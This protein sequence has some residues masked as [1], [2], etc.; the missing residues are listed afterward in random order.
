MCTLIRF[1]TAPTH[2]RW[3]E[4]GRIAGAAG[5]LALVISLCFG[6]ILHPALVAL[7]TLLDQ[8]CHLATLLL[9]TLS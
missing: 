7:A 3:W 6:G 5:L 2:L 9:L 8:A 1:L 4:W